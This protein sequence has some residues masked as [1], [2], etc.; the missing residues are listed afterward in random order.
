MVDN[1]GVHQMVLTYR[2]VNFVTTTP[3]AKLIV[4]DKDLIR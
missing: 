3:V 4:S 2:T 1:W